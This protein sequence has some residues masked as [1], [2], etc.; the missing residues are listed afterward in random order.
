M[1]GALIWLTIEKIADVSRFHISVWLLGHCREMQA[2][3][4]VVFQIQQDGA[5][6]INVPSISLHCNEIGYLKGNTVTAS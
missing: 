5:S 2:R 3:S 4:E 6:R 1:I